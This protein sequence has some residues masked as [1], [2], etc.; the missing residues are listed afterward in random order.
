LVE[1]M[2]EKQDGV[3]FYAFF[4]ALLFYM[5]GSKVTHKAELL[6]A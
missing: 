4:N 3:V 6:K 5:V 1:S 2:F